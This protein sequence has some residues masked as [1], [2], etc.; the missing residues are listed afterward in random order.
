[1]NSVTFSSNGTLIVSESHDKT[2]KLW[3]K[4]S[5]SLLK[6]FEG[7]QYLVNS[8]AFS[9]FGNRMMVNLGKINYLLNISNGN[10]IKTS[11]SQLKDHFFPS[12]HYFNSICKYTIAYKR[13]FSCSNMIIE[14]SIISHFNELILKQSNAIFLKNEKEQS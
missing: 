2:I 6:T 8:V 5:G 9:S 10:I 12:S 14:N 1:M 3:E 11:P 4:S 7:H 13:N